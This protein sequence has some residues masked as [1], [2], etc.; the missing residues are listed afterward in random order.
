MKTIA[1]TL[2]I[3]IVCLVLFH[4]GERSLFFSDYPMFVAIFATLSLLVSMT[5]VWVRAAGTSDSGTEIDDA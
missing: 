3:I 2:C 5:T 1:S 4:I